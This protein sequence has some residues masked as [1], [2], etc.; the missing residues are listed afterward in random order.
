MGLQLE[1]GTGTG[2]SA[3]IDGENRLRVFSDTRTQI[4]FISV[5]K[6]QSYANCR[7]ICSIGNCEVKIIYGTN[8]SLINPFGHLRS[9]S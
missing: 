5:E 6:E 1:D 2:S 3:K 9:V 8:V 4:A 7:L